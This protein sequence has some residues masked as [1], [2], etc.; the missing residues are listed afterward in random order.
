[1]SQKDSKYWYLHQNIR[2]ASSGYLIDIM[3]RYEEAFQIELDVS[4][5]RRFIRASRGERTPSVFI[6]NDDGRWCDYGDDTFQGDLI[7][8]IL[9]SDEFA[10]TEED[11]TPAA[12]D[13]ALQLLRNE[14]IDISINVKRSFNKPKKVMKEPYQESYLDKVIFE[15]NRN[16]KR[17]NQILDGFLRGCSS[18]E[19]KFFVNAFGV[20]YI[21]SS[22][23]KN[24][25]ERYIDRVFVPI[26]DEKGTAYGAFRYNREDSD[27]KVLERKDAR[28]IL[29]GAQMLQYFDQNQWL[30]LAEGRTD[31]AHFIA[32]GFQAITLG[33]SGIT[34][35]PEMIE[36]LQQY[37]FKIAIVYDNDKPG[38]ETAQRR[39]F[40]L[41]NAGIKAQ[42]ILWSSFDFEELSRVDDTFKVGQNN[43]IADFNLN[44]TVMGETQV[45]YKFDATDYFLMTPNDE[46]RKKFRK[47][48]W[49][50]YE[51]F[52][53]AVLNN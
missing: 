45:P 24:S 3:D 4:N 29:G 46:A 27:R 5:R 36:L 21:P 30:F 37:N 53:S 2:R 40:E 50:R 52:V 34:F 48:I 16:Q 7:D 17:F 22:I 25:G 51:E 39:L 18:G 10:P 8:L 11:D 9:E 38:F 33:G 35:K 44:Y 6:Y 47:F 42:I 26:K 1:M 15:R 14:D 31:W 23:D 49:P 12:F 19:K 13:L 32:K 43:Q 20:G 28:S 41:R